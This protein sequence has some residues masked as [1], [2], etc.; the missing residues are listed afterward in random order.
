MKPV[1]GG[2]V[3]FQE[4]VVDA[5]VELGVEGRGHGIDVGRAFAGEQPGGQLLDGGGQLLVLPL[6]DGAVAAFVF[7]DAFAGA[8]F[9][10]LLVDAP[11]LDHR[12]NLDRD[13]EAF[14]AAALDLHPVAD[15]VGGVVP[16]QRLAG[17]A[18]I[19]LTLQVVGDLFALV[20]HFRFD[21][22]P[23]AFG[24]RGQG[25]QRRGGAGNRRPPKLGQGEGRDEGRDKDREP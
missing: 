7:E 14:Q 19:R 25:R 22:G 8:L 6:G 23:L 20:G 18:E 4:A 16:A 1:L 17:G 2:G 15:L 11:E 5:F 10:F 3:L 21:L 9:R 12:K 24:V 13:V